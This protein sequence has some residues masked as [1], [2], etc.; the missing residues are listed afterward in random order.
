MLFISPH[1][2]Y[3]L[4]GIT[5]PKRVH[6]D[7]TGELLETQ[8]GVSAEF[9]HGGA[10]NWAIDQAVAHAP[11]VRCWSHLPEGQDH[12]SM[13]SSYDTD[14]QAEMRGWSAELKDFVE[15]FMLRHPDYGT[16][17]IL[18]V[19]PAEVMAAPW[20]TYDE[21]QWKQIPIIAKE[22][23]VDLQYVLEY[24]QAHK[25]RPGVTERLTGTPAEEE[26][27]VAA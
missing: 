22:I 20:P 2:Q 14:L 18:A 10:P 24:E 26:T 3:Q 25:N 5:K 12:R 13:V 4:V 8:P 23:G 9:F 17:Y 27:P 16:R 11:F 1:P 21:T 15:Q 7:A 19:N 6:H